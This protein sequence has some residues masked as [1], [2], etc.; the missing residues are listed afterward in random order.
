MAQ[1]AFTPDPP[2]QL[3]DQVYG[4]GQPKPGGRLSVGGTGGEPA[5]T[6]A[7]PWPTASPETALAP[8]PGSPR[9]IRILLVDDHEVVRQALAQRLRATPDLAV[10]GEAGTGTAAVALAR[11]LVP[12]VVLMD[13]N[14][15][16]MNGIEATRLIHVEFPS[17]RVIG[18]SMFDRGD[19]QSA[20]QAAGAVAYVSKSVPL[21]RCSRPFASGLMDRGAR[22]CRQGVDVQTP[23]HEVRWAWHQTSPGNLNLDFAHL[24]VRSPKTNRILGVGNFAQLAARSPGTNHRE[25]HTR[26]RPLDLT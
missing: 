4:D 20:M 14:L 15:P 8:A 24:A 1:G 19:Q 17:I 6:P 25:L 18:L 22:T 5:A 23:E 3:L 2:A 21:T 13:N 10:L 11:Q 9:T 12:D 7:L 26:T 16:E